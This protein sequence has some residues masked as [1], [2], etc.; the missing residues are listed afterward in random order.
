LSLY[1]GRNRERSRRPWAVDARRQARD[2]ARD[3]A[4]ILS[5]AGSE[6]WRRVAPLRPDGRAV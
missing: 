3:G 5:G 1:R 2:Q 4:S 6:R